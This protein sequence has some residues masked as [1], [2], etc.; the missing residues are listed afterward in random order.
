[1]NETYICTTPY[2]V[3]DLAEPIPVGTEVVLVGVAKCDTVGMSRV[4]Y[5]L[6]DELRVCSSHQFARH[7]VRKTPVRVEPMPDKIIGK[8]HEGS[9]A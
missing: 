8:Y 5:R 3:F 1:M 9:G 6:G 4:V 7:F 2:V